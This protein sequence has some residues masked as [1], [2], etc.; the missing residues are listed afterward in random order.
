M[1]SRPVPALFAVGLWLVTGT[2]VILGARLWW[3]QVLADDDND[4]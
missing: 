4:R 3:T 1:S 2:A